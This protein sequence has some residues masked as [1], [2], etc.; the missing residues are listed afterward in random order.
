[1]IDL[2]LDKYANLDSPFHHWDARYKLVGM[3]ALIFAFSFVKELW[4]LPLLLTITVVIYAISRLPAS[5]LVTRLK[6][7]GVFLLAAAVVLPL[8][9]GTTVLFQ[10]GPLAV[11]Q[12]G[13]LAFLLVAVRF[14]CILT[15]GIV[16]FGSAPFLTSVKAM[17]ALRLSPVLADMML[18]AYRYIFEI[19]HEFQT[20]ETAMRL[21]HFDARR[22]SARGLRTLAALSGTLIVRSYEQ[23]ERIYKAMVLRGYGHGAAGS[24]AAAAQFKATRRDGVALA[25][26]LALAAAVV[27]AQFM[28]GAG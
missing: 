25:L 8:F 19:G 17:R 4:L 21:R 27:A 2:G 9:S 6:Y 22:L 26:M 1:L 11:R 3:L 18:L 10:L 20:M 16:L 5:F 14:F 24:V 13:L 12:E 15:L 28:L 7:P 23:S